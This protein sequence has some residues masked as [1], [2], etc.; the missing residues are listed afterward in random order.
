MSRFVE[1]AGAGHRY[2]WTMTDDITGVVDKREYVTDARWPK[3]C[4]PRAARDAWSQ[5]DEWPFAF[6]V[7]VFL[8]LPA[9]L[10]AAMWRALADQP[11]SE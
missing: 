7:G 6:V 3:G 1:V 10:L 9:C 2:L 4:V 8:A 5:R 11:R